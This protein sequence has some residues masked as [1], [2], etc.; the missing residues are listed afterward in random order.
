MKQYDQ[1]AYQTAE[2]GEN[3]NLPA[4]GY[5]A[6]ITSAIDFPDK[7]YIKLE[8]EIMDGEW[9]GYAAQ[10]YQRAKFWPLRGVRSYKEAARAFFN[11]FLKAVTESNPGFAWDW[12]ERSLVKKAIGIVIGEREYVGNDGTVKVGIEISQ[13]RSVQ[14]IRDGKF[15][16]PAR[17]PLSEADKAKVSTTAAA[18]EGADDD[19]PF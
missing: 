10:T 1:S 8:F 14:A 16:V 5:I 3:R 18:C 2:D 19:L 13:I 4:G 6:Q 15:K 12:N 11:G 17:K 7:E 9:Q